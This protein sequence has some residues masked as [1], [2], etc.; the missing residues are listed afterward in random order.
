MPGGAAFV[1]FKSTQSPK[2]VA[3]FLDYLASAPIYAELMAK[4]ANIPAHAGLQKTGIKYDLPKPSAAALDAFTANATSLAPLA[5]TVQGYNFSRPIFNAD[6]ARLSQ[7]I[8]GE[9]TL[10]QAYARI[11]ADVQSAVAASK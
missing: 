2:E 6:V 7:V 11:T 8:V 9:L 3:H 10:D 5:Y 1:A 4:T